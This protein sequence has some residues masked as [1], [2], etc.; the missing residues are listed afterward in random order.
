MTISPILLY[1]FDSEVLVKHEKA[2]SI[3]EPYLTTDFV[4]IISTQVLH[5]FSHQMIR[6]GYS[7]SQIEDIVEPFL[8]W[9]VVESTTPLFRNALKVM[10]SYRLSIW[11]SLIIAAALE[12]KADNI[13][14]EDLN[15]GQ[16][17]G[18]VVAEN[19]FG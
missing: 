1:A 16:A 13:L 12:A 18:S 5:E 14:T 3:V 2:R 19:P 6:R 15:S 11:D 10:N 8:D 9:H 17:Y 4:P 7:A